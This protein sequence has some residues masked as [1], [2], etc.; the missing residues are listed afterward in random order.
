MGMGWVS[1]VARLYVGWMWGV[2]GIYGTSIADTA[3]T[4]NPIYREVHP[5]AHKSPYMTLI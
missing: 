1:K 2:W 3:K 5:P 4:P